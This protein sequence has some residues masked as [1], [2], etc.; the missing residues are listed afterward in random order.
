M[1]P[2]RDDLEARIGAAVVKSFGSQGQ[3]RS[4]VLAL[5]LA[6]MGLIRELTGEEPI[7]HLD[8]VASELDRQRNRLFFEGIRAGRGQV[9]IT[10]T[11]EC[12]VR[13]TGG[14]AV[15]LFHVEEGRAILR[16]QPRNK[17]LRRQLPSH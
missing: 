11:Q 13:V 14:G 7:L 1:G 3:H 4:F 12:D 9:F 5:K 8:D 2:H 17:R 10:A 16:K 15:R 6:E